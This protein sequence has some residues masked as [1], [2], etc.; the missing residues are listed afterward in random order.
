MQKWVPSCSP[1]S[2]AGLSYR[3]LPLFTCIS[4]W[5]PGL[6]SASQMRTLCT[7][8]LGLRPFLALPPLWRLHQT[9]MLPLWPVGG[10]PATPH[11]FPLLWWN[12]SSATSWLC[13][14]G[15]V[16]SHLDPVSSSVNKDETALATPWYAHIWPTTRPSLPPG[17][18][19]NCLTVG[20]SVL[21]RPHLGSIVW[22]LEQEGS[23]VYIDR[24]FWGLDIPN[25]LTEPWF[26]ASSFGR[27]SGV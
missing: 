12:P 4:P 1:Q 27:G 22:D 23:G 17:W 16:S 3:K 24:I 14:L 10:L 19:H 2:P 8:V 18:C 26:L 20:S 21:G 5:F 15:Q 11:P 13:D 7:F 9:M 25:I 6:Y